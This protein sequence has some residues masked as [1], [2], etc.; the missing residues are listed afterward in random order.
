MSELSNF[1]ASPDNLCKR[2]CRPWLEIQ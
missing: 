2:F 1:E